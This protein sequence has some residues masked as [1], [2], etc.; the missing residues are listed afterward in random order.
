[1]RRA[2]P[3][4][5][6]LV[7]L[8]VAVLM[9]ACGQ[10]GMPV[11]V[12]AHPDPLSALA[13]DDAS[14]AAHKRLVFDLWRTIVNAGHVERADD[15]LAEGYIQHSP[16]L[17]TGRAAFKQIFSAV[18]RRD[19]PQ[20]VEPP[21]VASIAEGDLV[22]MSLLESVPAG[23]H[24]PAFTTTHFNLF[25]VEDGRLAEHWHSVRTAPNAAVALPEEG[26]PQP[27]TGATGAAQ[28]ALLSAAD[29]VLAGNKRLV[30]DLWRTVVEAGRDEEAQRFIAMD[31][32]DH[33]PVG[34]SGLRSITSRFAAR[35]DLPV[36]PWLR[37]PLVAVV[38][39][40]DL[41]ALVRMQELPHPH[42][43]GRTYTLAWF[44]QFRIASGRI[45]EH[46][47]AAS[48]ADPPGAPAW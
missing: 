5:L 37:A 6:T 41:V 3:V 24:A 2:S 43:A 13:S 19:V 40:G 16:V 21:L 34:A 23:T 10:A 39:E 4:V 9:A 11:E 32:V 22:V 31:F 33:S 17:P 15:L 18:P 48:P 14:L 35:A 47:D 20:L 25:R 27:V 45:I 28:E 30:F 12:R 36:Q 26:G 42:H 29:P 46:W 44:D 7:P 1:M 8:A 38:A